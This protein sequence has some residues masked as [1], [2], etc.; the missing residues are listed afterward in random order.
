[1]QTHH[2][3]GS[4][5]EQQSHQFV[6]AVRPVG[7]EKVVFPEVFAEPVEA[8]RVVFAVVSLR[9]VLDSAGGK[10]EH[11]S[12]S[13]DGVAAS[14]LLARRLWVGSLVLGCIEQLHRGSVDGLEPEPIPQMVILDSF[15][16]VFSGAL[17]DHF[18]ELAG[19]PL[20]RPA[21]SRSVE[22]GDRQ[23]G[24][25]I[26]VLNACEGVGAGRIRLEH[27]RDPSPE[28]DDLGEDP[29][30]DVPLRLLEHLDGK[31]LRKDRSEVGDRIAEEIVEAFANI[32]ELTTAGFAVKFR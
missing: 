14:L 12:H 2:A 13:H 9:V 24:G 31:N 29:A 32:V 26:P 22:G 3:V 15:L 5:R 28:H 27:L 20:P 4:S 19:E 7:D 18:E 6:G 30:A 21:I 16:G 25:I 8:L 17:F 1:M 23:A 11:P 10:I